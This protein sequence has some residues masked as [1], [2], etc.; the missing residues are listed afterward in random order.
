MCSSSNLDD[1]FFLRNLLETSAIA[2][3]AN[4]LETVSYKFDPHGVTVICLLSESHISIHTWPE[5]GEAAVDVFTC[6]ESEPEIACGI[7][8]EA[9][10][11]QKHKM[12]YIKR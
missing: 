1:E 2:C 6:G 8:V 4:V 7:I 3:G 9:L 10:K 11:A 12:D 5:K